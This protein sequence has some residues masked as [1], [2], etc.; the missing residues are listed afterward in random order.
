MVRTLRVVCGGA[1]E[2]ELMHNLL[3]APPLA[4]PPHSPD[5][6]VFAPPPLPLLSHLTL[7]YFSFPPGIS[8][9][10]NVLQIVWLQ[11]CETLVQKLIHQ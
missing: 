7:V 4:Y 11:T 10:K 1:W 3:T 9:A 2:E 6:Q 8:E 5:I